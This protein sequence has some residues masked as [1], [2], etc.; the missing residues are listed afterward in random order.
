[1]LRSTCEGEANEPGTAEAL[2]LVVGVVAAEET[3]VCD[4]GIVTAADVAGAVGVATGVGA[5]A[6]VTRACSS[7]GD[8][9]GVLERSAELAKII[10]LAEPEPI[11]GTC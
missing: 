8:M 2:L 7:S 4:A 6:V 1:M 3:F 11:C 9:H 10:A 5:L